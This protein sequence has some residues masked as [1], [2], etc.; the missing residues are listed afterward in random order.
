M[1]EA[2]GA[3]ASMTVAADGMSSLVACSRRTSCCSAGLAP[4]SSSGLVASLFVSVSAST[5]RTKTW[6]KRSMNRSKF[7]EP[8]QKK[9]IALVSDQGFHLID[10]PEMMPVTKGDI[11]RILPARSIAQGLACHR[12]AFVGELSVTMDDMMAALPQACRNRGLARAG[13]AFDQN[14][15]DAHFALIG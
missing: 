2:S 9:E 1:T 13:H 12:I 8:P 4:N 10:V 5:S 6:S 14:V 7:R 11:S 3:V 15:S